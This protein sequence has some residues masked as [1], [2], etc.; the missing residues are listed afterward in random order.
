M[1]F[2]YLP[3]WLAQTLII[4]FGLGS[5]LVILFTLLSLLQIVFAELPNIQFQYGD[6]FEVAFQIGVIFGKVTML[7][8][9]DGVFIVPTLYLY[10]YI[11][12]YS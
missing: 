10:N 3:K 8:F 7:L 1:K 2:K 4:I 11:K 6:T 5:L 12:N 9:I